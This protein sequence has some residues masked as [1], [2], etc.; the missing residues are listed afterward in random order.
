MSEATHAEATARKRRVLVVEDEWLIANDI[1]DEVQRLGFDVVGP[2]ASVRAALQ[3][4]DSE[5]ADIGLLDFRLNNENSTPIA[6]E[7]TRRRIPFA[8]LTGCSARE[9]PSHLRERVVLKNR[10]RRAS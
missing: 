1:A 10:P 5:E 7:L 4:V 3:L 2:V 6:D 9:L 8:F